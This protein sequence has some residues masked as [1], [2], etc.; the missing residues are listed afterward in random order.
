MNVPARTMNSGTGDTLP[1]MDNKNLV[2]AT[3]EMTIVN[4]FPTILG[5]LTVK[6]AYGPGPT[7]NITKIITLPAGTGVRTVTLDSLELQTVLQ[8][9]SVLTVTGSV[10]SPTA[11]TVTPKQVLSI[12]N[13]LIATVR[14]PGG[15]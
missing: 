13:R 6:F 7:Q 1:K 15:K 14:T 12:D 11:I 4:P 8:S 9:K 5:N 3:L 10:S 2:K